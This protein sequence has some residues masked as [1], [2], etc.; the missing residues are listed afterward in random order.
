M[1]E[2]ILPVDGHENSPN[3]TLPEI[4]E[5]MPLEAVNSWE[6]T[7]IKN[8]A[9]QICVGDLTKQSTDAV[10]IMNKDS[11]N[12]M[13]GGELNAQIALAAGPSVKEE[14]QRIIAG[15]GAQ[16][17]GEAII[18]GAGNLPCKHLIHVIS[19]P[20]PPQILDLQLGVKKG[21]QLADARGLVSI[22]LPAI[23]AGGMRLSQV[24]SSR[25]LSGGILSFLERTPQSLREIKIV[26][27]LESMLWTYSQEMRK[28]FVPI[29]TLE[30]YSPLSALWQDDYDKLPV[31]HHRLDADK[32]L[33]EGNTKKPPATATQFRVYGKDRK[34]I[35]NTVNGLRT[36]FAK[37]CTV[38]RVTHKMVTQVTQCCWTSLSDVASQHDVELV[39][40]AH[41]DAITVRGN[42]DDVSLVVARIWQEITRL[43]EQ[44]SEAERRKLLAQYVRWHYVILDKEIG[45]NE[46][47]SATIED[48]CNRKSDGV[49]LFVKDCEYR[50]DFKAMTVLSSRSNYAP[51]RLSRRLLSESGT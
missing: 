30:E 33:S 49:S 48:A 22:S 13:K 15:S 6:C 45:I 7:W 36:V 1:N 4:P 8:T 16:L 12:L 2:E 9:I 35:M 11:L 17:P 31:L 34:S 24:D 10:V 26:L 38:H 40:E 19:Y 47:V 14:C 18:T 50:V 23:G 20:G 41:D 21:L 46:K 3:N 51:L 32:T 5:P 29:V 28:E 43:S 37:H 25:V 39:I 42:S 44:Q 27:Y